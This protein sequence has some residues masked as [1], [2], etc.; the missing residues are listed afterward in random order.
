MNENSIVRALETTP[1]VH[2]P[3]NFT[4]RV[5]A[6]VPQQNVRRAQLAG[7]VSVRPGLGRV[8]V[9]IGMALVLAAMLWIAPR[10]QASAD[11]LWMQVLL[12]AELS[13]LL[14]WFAYRIP[15]L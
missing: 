1:V 7:V 15:P 8:L 2:V 10:S 6:R 3:E 4:A 5:M 14:I 11:W 9:W 13:G 12:F